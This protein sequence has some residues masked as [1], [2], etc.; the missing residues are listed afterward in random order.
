MMRALNRILTESEIVSLF[1]FC[2]TLKLLISLRSQ[3][4]QRKAERDSRSGSARYDTLTLLRTDHDGFAGADVFVLAPTGMGK[5]S[6]Q[7]RGRWSDR[8]DLFEPEPML[9]NTCCCSRGGYLSSDNSRPIQF[10]LPGRCH[11]C[12]V[13][14]I[15]SVVS[16][17]SQKQDSHSGS[18]R[19]LS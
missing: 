5:V 10:F 6:D 7:F 1:R 16:D 15:G 12:C 18:V 19:Q 9:S 2:Q 4:V 11:N 14:S 17:V 3:R 13:T 8:F